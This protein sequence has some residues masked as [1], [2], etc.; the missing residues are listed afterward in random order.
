MRSAGGGD[1]ALAAPVAAGPH[2]GA[3]TGR[4]GDCAAGGPAVAAAGGHGSAAGAD[5]KHHGGAALWLGAEPE[6]SLSRKG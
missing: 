3:G 1:G 6:P 2:T 4:A 5:G